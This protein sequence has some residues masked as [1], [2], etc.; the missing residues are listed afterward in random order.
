MF[1]D[2]IDQIQKTLFIT[3]LLMLTSVG[4]SGQDTHYWTQQFGTRSALLGGA[5]LGGTNDNTMIYYNPAALAYLENSSITINANAYRI[6]NI[7]VENALGQTGDFDSAQLG[8]VPLLAG[9]MIRTN[10]QKWKI[11]YA[12]VSPVDFRFKG[13]ARLDGNFDV[14][15]E[16]ESPGLEETVG[17]TA[18]TQR[19][20][21]I[22]FAIGIGHQLDEHWSVGLSNLFT[23]R[24]QNYQR[25]FSAYIFR[26]DAERTLV[27]GNITQN[28]DYFNV[29]YAAKLGLVY[30]KGN[31]SSGLTITSPSLN[32]F[33]NGTL[34]SNIVV[35]N[36]TLNEGEEP[37][38]GI[39]TDRQSELKTTFK[40]PFSVALGTNYQAGRSHI[41]IV[42]QYFAG[43]D[44]YNIMDPVPGAFV[45]P[46]SLEPEI[47][48]DE[49]LTFRSGAKSV[50]NAAIG[51][52]YKLKENLSLL[53][54]IR[55]DMSYFDNEVNEGAGIKSTISSWDIYHFTAGMM[56]DKRNSSLSLGLLFS[57]GLKDDYVQNGGFDPENPNF[58]LG[59]RTITEAKFSSFGILL[60]YTYYIPHGSRSDRDP[61]N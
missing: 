27:G 17:E 52:E 33:G 21:E 51:Y 41:G 55:S 57:T 36:V 46:I 19:T 3:G 61:G 49:F 30:Q 28:A 56:L 58:Y 13:V 44:V 4:L 26:N 2:S 16:D 40:S 18:I 48:S 7:R 31:W 12:F 34:A 15:D 25:N 59:T 24:S 23:V 20:N 38:S 22:V 35:E 39:G 10:S 9:G 32:M 47:L 37:T 60:G 45:R 5:V 1:T 50:V 43:I 29:R 54:G 6:E 42:V 11:G 8:A 14:L 53:G